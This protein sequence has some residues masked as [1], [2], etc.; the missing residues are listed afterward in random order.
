MDWLDI[1]VKL[2]NFTQGYKRRWCMSNTQ[3]RQ[4]KKWTYTEKDI[5]SPETTKCRNELGSTHHCNTAL[6]HTHWFIYVLIHISSA[7]T[8][9]TCI[10]STCTPSVA[11]IAG[12]HTP[13]SHLNTEPCCTCGYTYTW[14]TQQTHSWFTHLWWTNLWITHFQD[15]ITWFI[16]SWFIHPWYTLVIVI[17]I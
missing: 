5:F 6:V 11:H 13:G 4:T 1:R 17:W 15:T 2:E 7:H 8:L 3:R 12:K 10:P 16:D 14:Y 9:G